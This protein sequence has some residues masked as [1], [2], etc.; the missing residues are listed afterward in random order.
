MDFH[1]GRSAGRHEVGGFDSSSEIPYLRDVVPRVDKIVIV[2]R[3]EL[4]YC[5][6]ITF[7]HSLCSTLEFSTVRLIT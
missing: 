3:L 2:A 5:R 7:V 6:T 4:P 1:P